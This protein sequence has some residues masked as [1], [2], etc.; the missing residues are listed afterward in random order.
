[1][2]RAR[3]RPTPP[4]LASRSQRRRRLVP[5]AVGLI[6][7]AAAV[8]AWSLAPEDP[9]RLRAR[10]GA[11][12]RAADWAAAAEAWGRFNR[13][14]H[15]DAR[16]LTAEA[17]DRLALGQAARAE[18]ALRRANSLD[19]G[20]AEPWLLRLELLRLEDRV[21]EARR[22]GREAL[23]AV[24]P[25]AR[26]EVLKAATLALLAEAPDDLARA[27]L[28]RWIDADP[29]DADARIALLRRIAPMP[30]LGDPDVAARAAALEALLARDPAHVDA[31]EALVLALADAGD[32]ARGR[33][34][35]DAWPGEPRDARYFRLVGRWDLDYGRRPARAVGSF[36][37]ALAELPHDWR[38]RAHLARAL[39]T[40][41]RSAEAR[42]E[43]EAVA[44]LRE[45][46]DPDP[47]GRRLAADFDHLDDPE[48]RR[49]L[50]D[51]CDR[52]GLQPLA[53]AWRGEPPA[54][55]PG[56]ISP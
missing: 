3:A 12:E 4:S 32:P 6:V 7:A 19:P 23:A 50:A 47:L 26:R 46:L 5:G 54:L 14:A 8:A 10:A 40:L 21:V 31:R 56:P 11:A 27:T 51:L 13:S 9:G 36:R 25:A 20:E 30:R 53:D 18:A 52:V 37:R 33:A 41:G 43:A 42:R 22:V 45:A 44:R 35:L 24:G 17:R 39:R 34:I 48:A 2:P 28:R 49:D 15:A 38:T 16:S 29:A 1:M 55:A